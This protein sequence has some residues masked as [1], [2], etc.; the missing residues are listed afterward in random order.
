MKHDHKYP[1]NS[2]RTMLMLNLTT[3]SLL[4][5]KRE[6]GKQCRPRTDSAG[7]TSDL[8]LHC[9]HKIQEYNKN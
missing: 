7:M 4:S 1:K 3:L 5:H 8:G 2:D 9:L 6:I